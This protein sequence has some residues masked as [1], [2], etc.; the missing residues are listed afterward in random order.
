[1]DYFLDDVGDF[2]VYLGFIDWIIVV[3]GMDCEVWMYYVV[4]YLV[5]KKFWVGLGGIGEFVDVVVEIY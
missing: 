4:G 1:M 3:L 2:G 5:G